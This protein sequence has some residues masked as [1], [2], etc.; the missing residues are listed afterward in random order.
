MKLVPT[1]TARMHTHLLV[2]RQHLFEKITG[3]RRLWVGLHGGL[4]LFFGFGQA[5]HLCEHYRIGH[6]GTRIGRI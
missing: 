4:R 3:L 6:V 5:V 1:L 2:L